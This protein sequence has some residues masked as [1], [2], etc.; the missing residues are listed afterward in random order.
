MSTASVQA[1]QTSCAFEKLINKWW[2]E[3]F[4]EWECMLTRFEAELA[5]F[6]HAGN[7]SSG[8]SRISWWEECPSPSVPLLL[9][10]SLLP[11]PSLLLSFPLPFPLLLPLT[12]FPSPFPSITP[13]RS[14]P[15][16]PCF[17]SPSLPFPFHS[18]S[19][20]H[21]MAWVTPFNA[22]LLECVFFSREIRLRGLDERS[23]FPRATNAFLTTLRLANAID[24][25][26][27]GL[28]SSTK[29]VKLQSLTLECTSQS[30]AHC[31]E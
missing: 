14:P 22:P 26:N 21:P 13:F 19:S 2:Y 18:L 30:P 7:R 10:P 12:V 3:I 1:I 29:E 25:V 16:L 31:T 17:F 28:F 9:S 23:S 6:E 5:N 4:N 15:T 11:L 8:R 20:P 27:F 24:D